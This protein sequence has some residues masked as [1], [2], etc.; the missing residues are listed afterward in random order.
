MCCKQLGGT[1]SGAPPSASTA[2]GQANELFGL[3]EQLYINEP[4]VLVAYLLCAMVTRVFAGQSTMTAGIYLAHSTPRPS[5]TGVIALL[6]SVI[7]KHA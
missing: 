4:V 5:P 7:G 6:S 1:G 3:L 2:W